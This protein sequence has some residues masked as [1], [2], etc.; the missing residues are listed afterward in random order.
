MP[1]QHQITTAAFALCPYTCPLA[2]CDHLHCVPSRSTIEAAK[3]VLEA[4]E[5]I[6]PDALFELQLCEKDWP[7]DWQEQFR[8]R[9]PR[10]VAMAAA[11]KKIEALKKTKAI[12]FEQLIAGVERYATAME[13]KDMKYIAHP[14]TWIGQGRYDDD[15]RS[16]DQS[17][18]NGH[19]G[20]ASI[21]RGHAGI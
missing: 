13:G 5:K 18:T 12:T 21:V 8:K 2:G 16:L 6:K 11:F 20:F 9:Y 3:A 14:A 17:E 1:T 15:A 19:G 10:K 4:I 7:Q